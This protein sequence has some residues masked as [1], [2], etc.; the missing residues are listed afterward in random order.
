M[1]IWKDIKG[2]EE[3]YKVS[4]LG[5]VKSLS[6][7]VN[8]KNN[9]KLTVKSKILKEVVSNTGYLVVNVYKN[10]IRKTRTIHQ[11]VAEKFLDHTP[12]GY[13]L[14]VDHINNT[15]T[16]NR[17]VNLQIITN[18]QNCSRTIKGSS[19]YTGVR[20]VNESKKWRASIVINKKKKNLG[21]FYDEY[22]AHL[23][24]QKEL[25]KL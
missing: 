7:I 21:M 24:Y 8:R 12:C 10:K 25:L 20:W 9:I 17:A 5:R 15:K 16:D 18:R 1:E 14:V 22:K 13:K 3:M 6:R 23:A 4:N 19:V 11:L 2:Y